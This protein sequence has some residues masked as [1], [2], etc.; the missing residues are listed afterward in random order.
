MV[1]N[2]SF[3]TG[4]LDSVTQVFLQGFQLPWLT[5][6]SKMAAQYAP[7]LENGGVSPLPLFVLWGALIY[8]IWRFKLPGEKVQKLDAPER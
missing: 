8:G 3:Q 4:I 1:R 7:F 2:Q 6:L 5:T